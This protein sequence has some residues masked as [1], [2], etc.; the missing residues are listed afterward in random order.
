MSRGPFCR[1]HSPALIRLRVLWATSGW[2]LTGSTVSGKGPGLKRIGLSG[3]DFGVLG[4]GLPGANQGWADFGVEVSVSQGLGRELFFRESYGLRRAGGPFHP[5]FDISVS[6]GFLPGNCC[7]FKWV[8]EVGK[9]G[10]GGGGGSL[11]S[12]SWWPNFVTGP[13]F[14]G[15]G[16]WHPAVPLRGGDRSWGRPRRHFS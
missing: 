1:P 6:F 16:Q 8:R 4:R 14:L 10:G 7:V 2:Q 11:D 5:F 15:E 9:T 13:R 3:H 12:S